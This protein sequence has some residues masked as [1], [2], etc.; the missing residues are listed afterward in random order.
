MLKGYIVE[1]RFVFLSFFS[2]MFNFLIYMFKY[3]NGHIHFWAFYLQD[4]GAKNGWCCHPMYKVGQKKSGLFL[5]VDNLSSNDLEV[6]LIRDF[7]EK[8]AVKL[9]HEIAIKLT[10]CRR[11][12]LQPR[13]SSWHKQESERIRTWDWYFTIVYSPYSQERSQSENI[14]ATC[15]VTLCIY[16]LRWGRYI[17]RESKKQDT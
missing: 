8:S 1:V 11:P 2:K 5:T 13:R 10:N 17:H 3:I 12:H 16:Y 4:G 7:V 6:W 14:S 15:T 9:G